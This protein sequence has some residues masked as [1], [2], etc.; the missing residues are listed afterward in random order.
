MWPV[1]ARELVRYTGAVAAVAWA[2]AV[3]LWRVWKPVLRAAAQVLLALVVIFEEWGWQ[4]LSA[5]LARLTRFKPWAAFELWL[6]GLPPYGALA[7]FAI[8]ITLL[9][10]LKLLAVYL[11]TTGKYVLG[12]ALLIGAKLTS[13]AIVARIFM[14]TK[15][16]L[17][18]IGWFAWAYAKFV[19]WEEEAMRRLRGSWVWRVG[20]VVRHRAGRAARAAWTALR[21]RLEAAVADLRLWWLRTWP[22]IRARAR[23]AAATARER[24]TALVRRLFGQAL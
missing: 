3:A 18:Q 7:A 4:P 9:F 23:E 17:M 16:A 15:P 19:P 22:R 13:T 21:P 6:A 5:A 2:A 10:P 20:R 11:F 24:M 8:P 14:L 12:T 1:I